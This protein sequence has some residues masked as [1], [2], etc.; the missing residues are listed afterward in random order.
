MELNNNLNINLSNEE[1]NSLP[2]NKRNLVAKLE[3][4][5]SVNEDIPIKVINALIYILSYEQK[6]S[7]FKNMREFIKNNDNI[8]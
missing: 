4:L 7:I 8:V 2:K 5:K 1:L 3:M 6:Q